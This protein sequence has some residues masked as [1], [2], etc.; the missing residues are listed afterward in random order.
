M[1]RL[2]EE[3]NEFTLRQIE[4]PLDSLNNLLRGLKTTRSITNTSTES[5]FCAHDEYFRPIDVSIHNNQIY[6]SM[7]GTWKVHVDALEWKSPRG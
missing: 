7:E 1:K 4:L 3:Q 5:C 6:F 2:E